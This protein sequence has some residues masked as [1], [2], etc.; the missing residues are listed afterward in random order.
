MFNNVSKKVVVVFVLLI[1]IS[2]LF[3]HTEPVSAQ[4]IPS[5]DCGTHEGLVPSGFYTDLYQLD[6]SSSSSQVRLTLYAAE[7]DPAIQ[8]LTPVHHWENANMIGVKLYDSNVNPVTPES[9][10]MNGRGNSIFENP[11]PWDT[12]IVS[13]G[14]YYIEVYSG[15]V[16]LYDLV[17]GCSDYAPLVLPPGYSIL[18]RMETVSV[19]NPGDPYP[20]PGGPWGLCVDGIAMIWEGDVELLITSNQDAQVMVFAA[21][22][23]DME[24]ELGYDPETLFEIDGYEIEEELLVE[25][26]FE[27]EFMY[28]IF[29]INEETPTYFS[30]SINE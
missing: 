12:Y 28:F 19:Q 29:V 13:P 6:L 30:I 10:F 2:V 24:D 20:C 27:P 5:I 3:S 9:R 1:L 8:G 14:V 23:T 21:E 16:D 25:I 4:N 18:E 15:T 11:F 22:L 26:T 17:V 7:A